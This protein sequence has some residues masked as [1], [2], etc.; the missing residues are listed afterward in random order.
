MSTAG[1]AIHSSELEPQLEKQYLVQ[2][3]NRPPFVLDNGQGVWL[4]DSDGR[5]YL[6]L[7]AGIA[8]NALGYGDPEIVETIQAAAT[9]P[10]HFSNLYHSEPMPR[11]AQ[12]LVEATP[13]A[14][15]VHF[16]NSGAEANEAAFKFAR[17]WARDALWRRQD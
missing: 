16:Q 2:A 17:K 10:L 7:V 3:Y 14:D 13:F 6:D 1:H 12:H 4:Q 11:L 5:R 9:K 8:V 15:R